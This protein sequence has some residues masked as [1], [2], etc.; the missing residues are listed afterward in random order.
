MIMRSLLRIILDLTK[1]VTMTH[2]SLPIIQHK[3]QG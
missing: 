2:S 3:K 1:H